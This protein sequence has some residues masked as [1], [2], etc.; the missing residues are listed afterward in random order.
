MGFYLLKERGAWA[1]LLLPPRGKSPP[2]TAVFLSFLSVFAFCHASRACLSFRLL[3]PPRVTLPNPRLACVPF[4]SAASGDAL[5]AAFILFSFYINYF[6]IEPSHKWFLSSMFPCKGCDFRAL[7]RLK[8]NA[9]DNVQD[10]RSIY[11][12]VYDLGRVNFGS[13]VHPQR[14]L[15][16]QL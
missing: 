6:E 3:L 12:Y 10:Y 2:Q 8:T 16:V 7:K 9:C 15:T 4:S 5:L 13:I 14:V 1:R 11:P